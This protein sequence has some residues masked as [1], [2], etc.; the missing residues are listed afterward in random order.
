[1]PTAAPQLSCQVR[2]L[3]AAA[4]WSVP[5]PPVANPAQ[6]ST[7]QKGPS[8]PPP[9]SAGTCRSCTQPQGG[10]QEGVQGRHDSKK[11][12]P[13]PLSPAGPERGHGNLDKHS[14]HPSILP[15]SRAALQALA[16]ARAILEIHF[17]HRHNV[18]DCLQDLQD[19]QDLQGLQDL[20]DRLF[21]TLL[22][23]SI[24]A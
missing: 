11:R 15:P 23:T 20:Q 7:E 5:S 18:A 22:L 21:L 2:G 12:A 1:M 14:N 19:L 10:G 16:A 24:P 17:G 3:D 6:K 4:P 13:T 8:S 9:G